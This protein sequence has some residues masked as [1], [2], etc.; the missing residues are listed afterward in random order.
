L[1]PQDRRIGHPLAIFA[2]INGVAMAVERWANIS[3]R[4]RQINF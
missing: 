2:E 4:G 1:R 3:C